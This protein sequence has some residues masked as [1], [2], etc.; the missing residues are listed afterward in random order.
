MSSEDGFGTAAIIGVGLLGGSIGL[1]LKARGRCAH[2]IGIGRNE[3][4]LEK[5]VS[6]NAVDSFTTDIESG[7]RDADVIVVCTPVAR[8]IADLPRILSAARRDAVVTDVGS[9]K[10][11]IVEAA[12]GDSRFIGSHPMA[13]SEA[14]GVEA[15]RKDLFVGAAWAITPVA[16]TSAKAVETVRAL[17]EAVGAVVRRL[18]PIDHDRAVSLVSHLP[19]VLATSLM[20]YAQSEAAGK[21]LLRSMSAGSFADATRVAA[22]SPELWRDICL[23]NRDA[24]LS[25]IDG[26][27]AQLGEARRLIERADGDSIE[28]YFAAGA[29]AKRSWR[30]VE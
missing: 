8:I 10:S 17:G 28:A 15:A 6:L 14:G 22:S 27:Q 16:A 11:A 2:V 26:L 30:D 9:V 3:A 13:G 18:D 20:L 19:H 5:A 12:G 1:A 29:D 24:I 23:G 7:C 21:P 25:A 4:R